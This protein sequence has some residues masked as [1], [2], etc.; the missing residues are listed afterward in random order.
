MP[1]KQKPLTAAEAWCWVAR[2]LRTEADMHN[3]AWPKTDAGNAAAVELEAQADAAYARA[4]S[5]G[6]TRRTWQSAYRKWEAV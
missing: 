5:L 4:Q 3:Y 1:S 2:M 6:A